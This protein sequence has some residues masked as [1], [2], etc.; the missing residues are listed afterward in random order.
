MRLKG[1]QK[2]MDE[3][4]LTLPNEYIRY[5]DWEYD[6]GYNC[7]KELLACEDRPTAIFSMND[8]MA[9]GCIHALQET[10]LRV[11]GDIAVVGFDNRE[12]ARYLQPPLTTV[13]LPNTEIGIRAAK[14]ILSRIQ[15]PDA[16]PQRESVPC[17]II[18]RESV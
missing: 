18:E 11:P 16:P 15:N 12:I 8:L 10:G 13:A 4:G 3:A 5:G 2:A 14:H 7:T 9:A 1:C 6:S 17:S